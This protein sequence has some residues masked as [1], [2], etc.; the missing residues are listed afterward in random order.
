MSVKVSYDY[1]VLL[2]GEESIEERTTVYNNCRVDIAKRLI[3]IVDRDTGKELLHKSRRD[4]LKIKKI[5][6][7]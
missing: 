1:E 2:D 6:A 3:L 4:I 7:E 5:P